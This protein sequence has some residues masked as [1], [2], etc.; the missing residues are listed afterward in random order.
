M[1]LESLNKRFIEDNIW[2][3]F[4]SEVIEFL[5]LYCD[6]KYVERIDNFIFENH[7]RIKEKNIFAF[8]FSPKLVKYYIDEGKDI[9]L[10]DREEKS[11][12]WQGLSLIF[13]FL[14]DLDK[15]LLKSFIISYKE[16]ITLGIANATHLNIRNIN[17]ILKITRE[18]DQQIYN[19]LISRLDI[20]T[21]PDHLND[22]EKKL[23]MKS[24]STTLICIN[25]I[26]EMLSIS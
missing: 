15:L 25:E 10:S 20:E 5:Y 14:F 7:E 18:L 19:N 4:N 24:D 2:G 6:S 12:E 22:I 1:D 17:Y 3:K 23:T 11:I 26:K 16:K 9:S 13:Y 21:F 8:A